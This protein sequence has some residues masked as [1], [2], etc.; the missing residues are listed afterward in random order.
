MAST[1]T[2]LSEH[3]STF[4]DKVFLERAKLVLRYDIG[5]DIKKLA[6]NMGKTVFWNRMTPLAVATTP[7]TE[8]TNPSSVD[9]TSTIVSAVVQEFGN[10]TNVG[11]LYSMTS[12]DDGLKEHVSVHGQN[13]GETI[14]TLIKNELAGGGTVQIVNSVA[15][16][17]DVAA[18]DTLDGAEVRKVV[19]NLFLGKATRFEDGLYRSIIPTSVVHDLRGDT[20]WLDAYRYTDA[21][22]IRD[23]DVGTLHGV[24]FIETN[25][26]ELVADAGSGTVDIY[27]TFFFG[28][29]AYGILDLAG[30]V[31]PRIIVKNPDSGDT[32]NPLNMFSTVGWKAFYATKVLNSAWLYEVKSASSVGAN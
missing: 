20:E 28:M 14:D 22:N 1:T 12:I 13:A 8:A 5:A 10:F 30:Q 31:G 6:R 18:T 27:T 17:T 3:M 26:E 4:Y 11:S 23:G 29:H 24:R 9:M 21:S 25:N 15:A 16:L 19:R 32:S 7:L 2:G